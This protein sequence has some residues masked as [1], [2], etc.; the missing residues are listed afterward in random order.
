MELLR[1]AKKMIQDGS[2]EGALV[3]AASVITHPN[4]SYIF[5]NLNMLTSEEFCCPF[6]ENASGYVRSD[7]SVALFLQRKQDA[8]RIY[9]KF[10]FCDTLYEGLLRHTLLGY[11]EEYLRNSILKIYE[12][13]GGDAIAKD[14]AF[15][16]LSGTAVKVCKRQNIS[17]R[18]E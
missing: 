6:D 7:G 4:S 13:N 16:E 1:L 5:D 2:I 10:N 11:D 14:L 18:H 12:R 8:K 17:Y 9:A 3:V 15:L